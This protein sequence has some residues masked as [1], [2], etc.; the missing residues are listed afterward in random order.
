MLVH[1]FIRYTARIIGGA[2]VNKVEW[3]FCSASM[4]FGAWGGLRGEELATIVLVI[5][6]ALILVGI[7]ILWGMYASHEE[8]DK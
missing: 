1:R 7:G 5:I 3:L 6:A 4:M 2:V 8:G